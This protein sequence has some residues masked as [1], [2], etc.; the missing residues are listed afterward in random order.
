MFKLFVLASLYA[1]SPIVLAADLQTTWQAVTTD[2]LGQPLP[3]PVTEYRVYACGGA[4]PIA[5]VTGT[6]HIETGAVVGT[7]TYCRAVAAFLSPFEGERSEATV[8][9]VVP[10]AAVNVHVQA[11][12]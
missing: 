6:S 2:D 3:A 8:V 12:P 1:L 7:G 10:G 4:E 5:I 9:V 11:L